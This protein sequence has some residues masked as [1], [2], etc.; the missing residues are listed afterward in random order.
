MAATKTIPK[1]TVTLPDGSKL[2]DVEIRVANNYGRIYN[3][4]EV[5][6]EMDVAAIYALNRNEYVVTGADGTVWQIRAER[7]CCGG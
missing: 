3:A 4:G 2:V 1:G 7:R 6:H 5:V